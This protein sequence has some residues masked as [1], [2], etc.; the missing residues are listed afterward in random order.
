M[1]SIKE[2]IEIQTGG[3]V[4][5]AQEGLYKSKQTFFNLPLWERILLIIVLVS[6][7]PGY[8]AVRYGTELVLTKLN[9][10]DS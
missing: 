6:L 9:A 4:L 7:V 2:N 3:A 5:A 10:R 8:T 1:A